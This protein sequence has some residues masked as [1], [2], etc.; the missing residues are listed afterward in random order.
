MLKY[1]LEYI[2]VAICIIYSLCYIGMMVQLVYIL[3]VIKIIELIELYLYKTFNLLYCV[4]VEND[5]LYTL[6]TYNMY[7]YE[8]EYI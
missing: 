2:F 4:I 8:Y 5:Y 1:L 3:F 7:E 6:L